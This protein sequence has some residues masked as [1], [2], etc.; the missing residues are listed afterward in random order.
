MTAIT[1]T[2]AEA[3]RYLPAAK[4]IHT[5]GPLR[6]QIMHADPLQGREL[7]GLEADRFTVLVMGGSQGAQRINEA[8][9]AALPTLLEEEGLQ[10]VHLT[11]QQHY[12]KVRQQVEQVGARAPAYQCHAYLEQMG[13]ALATADL[14]VSR[15]GSSSLAE[16]TALG[17]PLI[18]VPYPYAA[19]HQKYNAAAVGEVGA[20]EVIDNDSLCGPALSE[21]ILRLYRD[22]HS[23]QGMAA[24]S[25]QWGC[26][27]AA[28]Q[29][30]QLLLS[31]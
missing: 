20:A 25:Q 12:E 8:L 4:V 18:L 30:A 2:F 14:V 17:K 7:L 9:L 15:A 1:V 22:E 26:T 16:A 29:I 13:P 23:C 6:R 24:A 27:D 11:G 31:Y 19:G 5:G 10:I 3:G 28:E 21:A